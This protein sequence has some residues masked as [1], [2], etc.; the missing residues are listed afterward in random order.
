MDE[1]LFLLLGLSCD[2]PSPEPLLSDDLRRSKEDNWRRERE[3]K[4]Y[5]RKE[6]RLTNR[7]RSH[8]NI[9]THGT[10]IWRVKNMWKYIK[11]AA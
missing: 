6:L 10:V 2:L 5:L 11:Y 3:I 7:G 1:L 4:V 9:A 8:A